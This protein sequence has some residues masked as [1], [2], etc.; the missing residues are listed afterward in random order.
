MVSK[1]LEEAFYKAENPALKTYIEKIGRS[2]DRQSFNLN[3][4]III[5]GLHN[6]VKDM[7]PCNDKFMVNNLIHKLREI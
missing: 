1:I 3:K 6:S 7:K 2:L 4:K 5:N